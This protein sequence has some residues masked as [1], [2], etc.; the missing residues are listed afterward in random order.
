[1][2]ISVLCDANYEEITGGRYHVIQFVKECFTMKY[3]IITTNAVFLLLS[4]IRKAKGGC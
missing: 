4:D 2:V 3:K 1:M